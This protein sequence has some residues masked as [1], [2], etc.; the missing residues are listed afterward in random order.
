MRVRDQKPQILFE[1]DSSTIVE[2][3]RVWIG[4]A[5]GSTLEG[6]VQVYA[7]GPNGVTCWGESYLHKHTAAYF[8]DDYKEFWHLALAG[9]I[10]LDPGDFIWAQRDVHNISSKRFNMFDIEVRINVSWPSAWM[11][12]SLE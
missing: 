1:F 11:P 10:R 12:F 5:K 4:H 8:A 3:G 9:P 2:S 7:Q 6:N